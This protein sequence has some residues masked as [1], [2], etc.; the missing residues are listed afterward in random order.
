MQGGSRS[1][2]LE[3]KWIDAFIKN[4]SKESSKIQKGTLQELLGNFSWNIRKVSRNP[5]EYLNIWTNKL[6]GWSYF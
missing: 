2:S 6:I 1:S 5:V 3:K 4:F